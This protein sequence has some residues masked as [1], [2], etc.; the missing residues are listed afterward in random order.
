Y[1]H[2]A[3][4]PTT[5][6]RPYCLKPREPRCKDHHGP[7]RCELSHSATPF[8][9][10]ARKPRS[11]RSRCSRYPRAEP[12]TFVKAF[13]LLSSLSAN[14]QSGAEQLL[15]CLLLSGSCTA[16]QAP[17]SE[18][19]SYICRTRRAIHHFPPREKL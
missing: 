12:E 19:S 14:R 17:G 5:S 7:R 2:T 6:W 8:A 11:C 1:P 16:Q 9:T 3:T 4:D 10:P 18:S 13:A 15:S